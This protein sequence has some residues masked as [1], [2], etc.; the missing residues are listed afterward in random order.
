MTFIPGD[1]TGT[2][3]PTRCVVHGP[4][5]RVQR[6]ANPERSSTGSGVLWWSCPQCE[7]E[8]WQ[9]SPQQSWTFKVVPGAEGLESLVAAAQKAG[10]VIYDDPRTLDYDRLEEGVRAPCRRINE[11]GWVFTA[12]SCHGHVHEDT[13][14]GGIWGDDPFVRL[15]SRM[16]HFGHMLALF[17]RASRYRERLNPAVDYEEERVLSFNVSYDSRGW[18]AFGQVIIRIPSPR[19]YSRIQALAAFG[20][21]A[22]LVNEEYP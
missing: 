20:R 7:R 10:V 21:F 14:F 16:E 18:P 13:R 2:S 5:A 19:V 1:Y 3:D 17:A 22:Q 15:A 6:W 9:Q 8:L 4:G 11:S 12:E